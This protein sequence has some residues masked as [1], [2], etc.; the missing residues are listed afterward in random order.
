MKLPPAFYNRDTCTV[1]QDLLG[2]YLVRVLDGL[3]LALRI[4]ETEAYI[5][6]LDKAC[7]AYGY[8]RTPRTETL[9]AA[10]G[11]AY[12]YL[13]YGM[14]H[15]LNFV[16]EPEGEPA[17]VL[18]R[19]GEARG[20][21][22][23]LSHTRYGKAFSQLSP[24]QKKNFLNG[25]GK[26]CKALEAHVEAVEFPAASSAD[27]LP[28]ISRRFK[29][30]GK[31]IDRTAAEYLVTGFGWLLLLDGFFRIQTSQKAKTFGLEQWGAI[32]AVAIAVGVIG[33]RLIL[34]FGG[35]ELPRIWIILA[36]L[37]E[38]ILNRCVVRFT[39]KPPGTYPVFPQNQT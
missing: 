17:A 3:P 2:K 26:L 35:T 38:G 20:D 1:A 27:L 9:F 18:I 13:I 12:I 11:T 7:H 30:L 37:T 31:E 6:R 19:G 24:Y 28:W 10:P 15:C 36:F 29:A 16:T 14:Y 23:L 4:N 33:F 25:P 32:S 39:V 34:S 22:E 21:V 8:R 5:G